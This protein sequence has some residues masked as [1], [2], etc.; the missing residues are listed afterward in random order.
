[1]NQFYS[2][3]RLLFL[4]LVDILIISVSYSFSMFLRFDFQLPNNFL[5]FYDKLPYIIIFQITIFLLAGFY[6]SI[7]RFTSL[8]ELFSIVKL[9]TISK[10]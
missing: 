7:W 6:K 9:S 2:K 4:V 5:L 8:Y 3:N 1:M 10:P